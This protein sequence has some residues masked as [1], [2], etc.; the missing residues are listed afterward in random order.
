MGCWVVGLAIGLL[1][2]WAVGLCGCWAVRLLGCWAVGLLVVGL[3][4]CW[5]VGLLRSCL[6]GCWVAG[7][8]LLGCWVVGLLRSCLLGCWVA[9]WLAVGLL[10]CWAVGLLLCWV[11]GLRDLRKSPGQ[12]LVDSSLAR[13]AVPSLDFSPVV[14]ESRA[15]V[16]LRRDSQAPRPSRWRVRHFGNFAAFRRCF[17]AR[18]ELALPR[19]CGFSLVYA[20]FGALAFRI[21]C[22]L[23]LSGPFGFCTLSLVFGFGFPHP[24]HHQFL[25]I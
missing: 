4:G 7:C 9:G 6:L 24:Q 3:L 8:W 25:P 13:A 12:L 17:R 5:V 1:G 14:N 10:G 2:C 22:I 23:F 18:F 11:V 15:A 16:L 19:F 21:L 20:A